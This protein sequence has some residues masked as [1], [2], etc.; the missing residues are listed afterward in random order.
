MFA[1]L[2]FGRVRELRELF[3]FFR[4]RRTDTYGGLLRVAPAASGKA[5][6]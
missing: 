6:E 3:Q 4:D 2:D 5:P 1:D